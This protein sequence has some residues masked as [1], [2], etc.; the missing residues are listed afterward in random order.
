MKEA[1]TKKC[2]ETK[3]DVIKKSKLLSKENEIDIPRL[4][5]D[6]LDQTL[7]IA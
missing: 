5:S 3:K 7:Q 4:T 6:Y 2:S 1:E